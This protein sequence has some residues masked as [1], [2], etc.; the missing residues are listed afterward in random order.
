LLRALDALP[1]RQQEVIRLKFQAGLSYRD[2]GDV[3]GSSAGNVGVLIH[4]GLKALRA[5]LQPAEPR[6]TS[7]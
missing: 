1:K 5:R 6:P 4:T 7:R 3:V 2:I